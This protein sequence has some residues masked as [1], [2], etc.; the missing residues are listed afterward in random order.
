MKKSLAAT[1]LGLIVFSVCVQASLIP[2]GTM[3]VG[4]GGVAGTSTGFGTFS[5]STNS[6]PVILDQSGVVPDEYSDSGSDSSTD[7]D[8]STSASATVLFA[9]GM[10][11]IV[12]NMSFSATVSDSDPDLNGGGGTGFGAITV[13]EFEWLFPS[14]ESITLRIDQSINSSLPVVNGTS[15][16]SGLVF[17]IFDCNLDGTVCDSEML[18]N[19][20]SGTS[21]LALA[22]SV[23]GAYTIIG[24]GSTSAGEIDGLT[25]D[26][27]N[28]FNW[29]LKITAVPIPAAVWLFGSG[30]L[31]LIGIAR[32]K[33]A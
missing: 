11:A 7:N 2:I 25:Q 22:P 20:A 33:K 13:A 17:S 27:I 8:V 26:T 4:S 10:D 24:R 18:L 14:T 6:P 23:K 1:F 3:T 9:A 30:L 19:M 12:S 28:T 32:R 31:G 16:Q 15:S 29:N 21:Q 5:Q